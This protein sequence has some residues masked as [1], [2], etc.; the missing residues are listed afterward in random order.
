MLSHHKF[1]ASLDDLLEKKKT[2]ISARISANACQTKYDRQIAAQAENDFEDAYNKF[3]ELVGS[4]LCYC[5]AEVIDKLNK[6]V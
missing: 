6:T 2:V 3:V 1:I 4:N 5:S